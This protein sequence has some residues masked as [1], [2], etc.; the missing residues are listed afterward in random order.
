MEY[1]GYELIVE[2]P[3]G[4]FPM[5][6]LLEWHGNPWQGI[7]LK[8]RI[9]NIDVMAALEDKIMQEDYRLEAGAVIVDLVQAY[10]GPDALF[11]YN[12]GLPVSSCE[13]AMRRKES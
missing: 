3:N 7:Q 9:V 6:E 12:L 13:M 4:V 2:C 1:P 11:V 10:T 5:G 8:V